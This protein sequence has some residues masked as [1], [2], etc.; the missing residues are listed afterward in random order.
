MMQS[1]A[2]TESSLNYQQQHVEHDIDDEYVIVDATARTESSCIVLEAT[3]SHDEHS[4]DETSYDYCEDALPRPSPVR[5]LLNGCPRQDAICDFSATKT[6]MTTTPLPPD[7]S[8]T[9][10]EDALEALDISELV[11]CSDISFEGLLVPGDDSATE[12]IDSAAERI[13]VSSGETG[14]CNIYT[15][16]S[17]CPSSG[18]TPAD[19]DTVT[20]E[21]KSTFSTASSSTKPSAGL[22]RLSNKKRRKQMKIAKK[23]AAAA[24]TLSHVRTLAALSS[25]STP[26]RNR[27]K[28][29]PTPLP[30]FTKKKKQVAP[31]AAIARKTLRSYKREVAA[32]FH[33]APSTKTR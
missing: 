1:V 13:S 19:D 10:I 26:R 21:S 31:A 6:T 9:N 2:L 14:N 23:A 11:G 28:V 25:P 17:L 16:L 29:A 15:P 24:A 4:D 20:S 18:R 8:E 32:S 7:M 3:G 33:L 30:S 22:G 27:T 12:R 5:F